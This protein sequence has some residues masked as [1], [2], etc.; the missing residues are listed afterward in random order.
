MDLLFDNT[1][2]SVEA[3]VWVLGWDLN[4]EMKRSSMNIV[5]NCPNSRML[6]CHLG[7]RSFPDNFD[8]LLRIGRVNLVQSSPD[9]FKSSKFLLLSIFFDW[10]LGRFSKYLHGSSRG[11]PAPFWYVAWGCPY[12]HVC[13]CWPC[14]KTVDLGYLYLSFDVHASAGVCVCL[15]FLRPQPPPSS[16]FRLLLSYVGLKASAGEPRPKVWRVP[17]LQDSAGMTT[18]FFFLTVKNWFTVTPHFP[19]EWNSRNSKYYFFIIILFL[20]L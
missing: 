19:V 1:K 17:R 14:I 4:D 5:W 11:S 8:P 13:L 9:F 20:L 16:R 10:L 3:S 6:Q 18:S 15:Y 7:P 2:N 12:F